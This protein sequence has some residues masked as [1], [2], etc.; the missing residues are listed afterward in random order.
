MNSQTSLNFLKNIISLKENVSSIALF[1]N[2][3]QT[4]E[5]FVNKIIEKSQLKT[6]FL[7]FEHFNQPLLTNFFLDCNGLNTQEI[8]NY[9]KEKKEELQNLP[10]LVNNKV[11]IIINSLNYIP[12]DEVSS[13]FFRLM[14]SNTIVFCIFHN[15]IPLDVTF[16]NEYPKT[17][18]IMRNLFELIL[19]I[20]LI[21][22]YSK[23]LC[24]REKIEIFEQPQKFLYNHYEFK[25][26]VEKKTKTGKTFT[27]N[28]VMN[29]K[30]D[31]YLVLENDNNQKEESKEFLIKNLT[32]FNLEINEKQK[33]AKEKIVLPYIAAQKALG[34][35]G[36]AIIYDDDD[37]DLDEI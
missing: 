18:L 32:T 31:T 27:N 21:E 20:D 16:R 36:G 6:I 11:L 24:L 13:F 37:D 35:S 4:S 12:E 17:N 5:Y 7:S 29:I 26:S 3:L 8:L 23:D 9:V 34:S 15:D 19:E 33:D 28:Y 14:D 10:R 1:D 22:Y 30:N 2:L 25:I